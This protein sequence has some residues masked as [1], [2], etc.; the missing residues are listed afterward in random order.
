[1]RERLVHVRVERLADR[2][3]ALQADPGDGRL[4]PLPDRP[5]GTLELAVLTSTVDVV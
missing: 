3:E 1:M 5:E 2:S 4:Q